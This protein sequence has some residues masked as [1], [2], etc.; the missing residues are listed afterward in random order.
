MTLDVMESVISQV[1][2]SF[3]WELDLAGRGEP[4][5]HPQ[6]DDL[7]KIMSKAS[8]PTAV[9]TTGVTLNQRNVDALVNNIDL[10]RLLLSSVSYIVKLDGYP[11]FSASTLNILENTE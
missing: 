11:I 10:I 9:V 5:I 6:F 7:L 4:T 1:D 3:V 8:V 2:P